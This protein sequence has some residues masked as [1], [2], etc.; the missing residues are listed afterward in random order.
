MNRSMARTILQVLSVVSF[1]SCDN[2]CYLK[3]YYDLMKELE[4]IGL[5]YERWL[6]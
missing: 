4:A 1:E 6:R 2:G 3:P 5:L